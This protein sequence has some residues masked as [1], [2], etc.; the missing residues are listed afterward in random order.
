MAIKPEK[1]QHCDRK[2]CAAC[3]DGNCVALTETDFGDRECPFFK[4]V[5]QV[6]AEQE[7]KKERLREQANC[8]G[9]E[10]NER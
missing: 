9:R 5:A 7:A 2:D 1:L 6:E 10:D 3:F 8:E 4:T